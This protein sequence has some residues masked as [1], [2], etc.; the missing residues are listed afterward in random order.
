MAPYSRNLEAKSEFDLPLEAG[1]NEIIIFF[2]DLAERDARYFFQLDY[3]E[4]PRRT[5]SPCRFRCDE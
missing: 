3:L 4:R 1:L 5:A 2:D